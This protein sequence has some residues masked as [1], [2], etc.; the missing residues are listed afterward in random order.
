M[1]GSRPES[2]AYYIPTKNDDEGPL[3]VVI[4]GKNVVKEDSRKEKKRCGGN[5]A[6]SSS[7]WSANFCNREEK[8][9]ENSYRTSNSVN[10]YHASFGLIMIFMCS[11]QFTKW[12]C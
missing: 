7:L 9:L 5:E 6:G 12:E 11:S 2:I 10:K 8:S 3:E 1:M 4:F